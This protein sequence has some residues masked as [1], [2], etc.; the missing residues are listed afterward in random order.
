VSS[1]DV[2]IEYAP[3]LEALFTPSRYKVLYGGRGSGKSWGVARAL[4]DLGLD[5]PIRVLCARE[6]QKTISESVHQLLKDQIAGLGLSE[7][8]TVQENVIYGANG[9]EFVFAGIRGLD[10]TKIKSFEN[11][12]YC[13]VEEGQAVTRKSWD[14]LTPTIRKPGSEIWVTFNPDLDTDETYQR[15]VEYPPNDCIVLEINWRDNPWFTGELEKER[16]DL[17][18]KV[19]QGLRTQD[20]YENIWEGKCRSAEVGAIYAREMGMLGSRVLNLPYDPML[21]VHTV[22]DLGFNDQTSIIFVQRNLTAIHVIDYLEDNQKTM[23]EYVEMLKAKGYNYGSDWLPWDG[24]EERYKLTDVTNSPQGILKKLQR[25][26]RIVDKMDVESGIKK[27]RLVFPR[28]YF[29]K[30]KTVRLRECLKRYKRA[31]PVSTD[32]PASPVHDVYSHGADAFRYL[33]VA[34]EKMK[35][36][37]T[38]FTRKIDY[39]RH[40]A[41]IV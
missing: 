10:V 7:F 21:K 27:A 40:S 5:K 19:A 3:K 4:L 18:R 35:N 11:V 15:F 29:D 34:V 31:V 1:L 22:W 16:Q 20:D 38:T 32:E 30:G 2:R 37:D 12:D 36:D 26:V 14:V 28:C 9:T 39:S 41:G 25:T 13:W 17:L 23:A 8:Y 6:I 33:A 24:S